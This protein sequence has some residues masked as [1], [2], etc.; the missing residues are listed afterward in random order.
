MSIGQNITIPQGY[1]EQFDTN[2]ISD[3]N[4]TKIWVTVWTGAV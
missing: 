4:Q 3:Q 1:M 2:K